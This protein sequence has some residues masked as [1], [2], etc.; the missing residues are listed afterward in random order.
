MLQACL[1]KTILPPSLT[2]LNDAISSWLF[3]A[4]E[5]LLQ[6]GFVSRCDLLT[7]QTQDPCIA[8]PCPGASGRQ[9]LLWG[10]RDAGQNILQERIRAGDLRVYQ[11]EEGLHF[12]PHIYEGSCNRQRYEGLLFHDLRRTGVRN[13]VR[14]GV[15]ERVAMDDSGHKT[16]AVF[17]RYNIVNERD[18]KDAAQKLSRYLS[19]E[20]GHS[21]GIGSILKGKREL[22]KKQLILR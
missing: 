8:K 15:P 20:F 7:R 1:W 21:S 16:R 14:A 22:G 12:L 13:L 18:L 11:G 6:S 5:D 3:P 19:A 10:F 17:D 2:G 4:I 9:H